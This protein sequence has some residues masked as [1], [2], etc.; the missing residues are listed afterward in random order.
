MMMM[1]EIPF[2]THKKWPNIVE[3][4]QTRTYHA[5]TEKGEEGGRNF[6]CKGGRIRGSFDQ[7]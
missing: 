2:P 7:A 3:H 5:Q 4:A 1:E 6:Q